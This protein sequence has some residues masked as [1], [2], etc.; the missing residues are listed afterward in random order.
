MQAI[1][2]RMSGEFKQTT[3]KFHRILGSVTLL[4]SYQIIF[5]DSGLKFVEVIKHATQAT[6]A[7][8]KI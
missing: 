7:A 3:Q 4:C 8:N 1:T 6:A 2:K 5:S